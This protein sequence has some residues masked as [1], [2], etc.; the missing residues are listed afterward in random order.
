MGLTNERLNELND[1][2][3]NLRRTVVEMIHTAGSGHPGGSLSCL[4]IVTALY[5]EKMKFDPHNPLDPDRDRFVLSK[6]HAAPA[7]YAILAYLGVIPRRE[8]LTLRKLGSRLQGHPDMKSV[9]GVEMSAGPLGLGL[10]VSV[11]MALTARMDQASYHT[12]V[13]LGDGETQEGIIWEAAMTAHKYKLHNLT[14][15]L[16][17]NGVQLDGCCQ[18]IMPLGAV[19]AKF[20]SFGWKTFTCDGHDIA[21]ILTALE[22]ADSYHQGPSIIIAKTVKGKGVSFMEG[23]NIWHGKKIEDED[24]QLAV[25][26]IGGISYAE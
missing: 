20:T 21:S 18:E 6:G 11:G 19:E 2:S 3:R 9:P 16:D 14:A 24:Y 23:K 5:L 22:A 15:I 8:L 1:I 26:E 13:L 10:S 25:A 7:L 4:E 12:Y 17:H